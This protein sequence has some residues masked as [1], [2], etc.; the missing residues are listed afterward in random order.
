[1]FILLGSGKHPLGPSVTASS[2][3][4]VQDGLHTPPTPLPPISPAV[5]TG[6]TCMPHVMFQTFPSAKS[7]RCESS[8]K[9]S[10]IFRICHSAGSHAGGE[11]LLSQ[12]GEARLWP[13][14]I[15]SNTLYWPNSRLNGYRRKKSACWLQVNLLLSHWCKLQFMTSPIDSFRIPSIHPFY[16]LS[17]FHSSRPPEIHRCIYSSIFFQ[18]VNGGG[19]DYVNGWD[20]LTLILS[21]VNLFQL[22]FQVC[23]KY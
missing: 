13:S 2:L 9:L 5:W 20:L 15:Q 10:L 7:S 4:A 12:Q 11:Y 17:I 19:S 1:M 21:N 14:W 18:I 3:S 22:L 23:K 16:P 6:K 8:T